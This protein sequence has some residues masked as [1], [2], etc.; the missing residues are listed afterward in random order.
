MPA[1]HAGAQPRQHGPGPRADGPCA[2]SLPCP[3]G[4]DCADRKPGTRPRGHV[5]GTLSIRTGAC[6]R[7]GRLGGAGRIRPRLACAQRSCG[8]DRGLAHCGKEGA[9]IC[10]C[11]GGACRLRVSPGFRRRG[12]VRLGTRRVCGSRQCRNPVPR[13]GPLRA[14]ARLHGRHPPLPPRCRTCAHR[15]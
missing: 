1:R 6:V 2:G 11:P 10:R 13:C 15:Q 5:D 9:G 3:P 12:V 4:A 7:A 14:P 8:R